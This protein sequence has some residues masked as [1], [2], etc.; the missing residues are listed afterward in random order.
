MLLS[1]PAAHDRSRRWHAWIDHGKE[2][3]VLR[4]LD[5]VGSR[6]IHQAPT[7]GS[8]LGDPAHPDERPDHLIPRWAPRRRSARVFGFDP[9]WYIDQFEMWIAHAGRM[10]DPGGLVVTSLFPPLLRPEARDQR[11]LVHERLRGLGVIER[12]VPV[13]YA[14]PRFEQEVLDAAGLG[15]LGHWRVAEM[16]WIRV[17][18]VPAK[19]ELPVREID[20]EWVRFQLG[21][22]TIA[23]R[24]D[25][26]DDATVRLRPIGNEGDFRLRSVSTRAPERSVI[27]VWTSRNRAASATGIQRVIEFLGTLE[28]GAN[29]EV[30]VD[31][32]AEEDKE[33]LCTLLAL[34]GP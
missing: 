12:S 29:P 27:N 17:R 9:P 26:N 13:L 10:V 16:L 24:S 1:L 11:R 25:P 8:I 6:V 30:L 23:V 14:T 19:R 3:N 32:A 18:S 5:F 2:W 15:E 28:I 4:R 34:I 7:R 31:A 21:A 20:P 22:Q 33:G